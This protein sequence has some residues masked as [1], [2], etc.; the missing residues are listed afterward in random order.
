MERSCS[1]KQLEL[2]S[3]S[4]FDPGAR[5][6]SVWGQRGVAV[7]VGVGEG[8]VVGLRVGHVWQGV[9]LLLLRVGEDPVQRSL[10]VIV[11]KEHFHIRHINRSHKSGGT[12]N[13]SQRASQEDITVYWKEPL[14]HWLSRDVLISEAQTV[15]EVKLKKQI[16]KN[17]NFDLFIAPQLTCEINGIYR[18][19]ISNQTS[20]V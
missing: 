14:L 11:L 5:R 1:S 7:R 13:N 15:I 4:V 9:A 20:F 16:K 2:T 18:E 12:E 8:V 19:Y 3:W 17:W 6:V 10:Q